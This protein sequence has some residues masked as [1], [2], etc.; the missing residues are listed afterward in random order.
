MSDFFGDFNHKYTIF[1]LN[2]KCTLKIFTFVISDQDREE[3]DITKYFSSEK[4][5]ILST[6]LRLV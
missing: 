3:E 2:A 5:Q 1:N 6:S 4:K